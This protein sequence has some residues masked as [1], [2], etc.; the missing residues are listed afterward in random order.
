MWDQY[1]FGV[2]IMTDCIHGPAEGH[3]HAGV[4]DVTSYREYHTRI[5]GEKEHEVET[6]REAYINHGRWIVN[7]DCA[8]AGLTSRS[9]KV[10]CCFDCGAVY[11]KIKFPLN[12]T[13]I[14]SALLIRPALVNRNW[15]RGET[16]ERLLSENDKMQKPVEI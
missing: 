2:C 12:A 16:L 9:W 4:T 7:C 14:E 11:T 6:V 5:V 1:K 10:S 8:G 3:G 15:M 13:K